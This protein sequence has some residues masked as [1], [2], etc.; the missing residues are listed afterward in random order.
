MAIN[1]KSASSAPAP[2]LKNAAAAPIVYFDNVP[3]FG[4]FAGNLEIE[5]ATRLLMPKAD[6]SVM[7]DMT[8]AAHLR[9][10][11][12]AAISLVEALSKALD[13]LA[14]QKKL[15][16]EAPEERSELLVN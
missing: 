13:M 7:A 3:V 1:G 11:E 10:S 8:C 4:T 15:Q 2:L 12:Q 9:C 5:L 6:G 16:S 14:K